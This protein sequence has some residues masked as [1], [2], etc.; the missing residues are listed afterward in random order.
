MRAL[1]IEHDHV[2]LGGPIWRA[3]EARGYEIERFLII[4]E[5]KYSTPNVTVEFPDFSK[6]DIIVP[7]GAPYGVYETER[8]GNWLLPEL[9]LLKKAHNAGQPIFGICFGGQLM[10]KTLGGSVARAPKAELGWYEIQ[11]DDTSIISTGPW[12]EYHWDRWVTPPLAKEIARTDLA[13]QA[14][15]LGRTLA[16]QFHPEINIEVLD[17]WLAMDGGCAEVESEGVEVDALRAQTKALQPVTDQNAFDL[18]NTFLDR[19]ATAQV[20]PVN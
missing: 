20:V 3:F 19:I 13:V 12:F 1:F 18:V 15:T 14:F 11:S 5:E 10:A 4:P 2:S 8:V 17:E 16:L 7:M 6:F 9:D